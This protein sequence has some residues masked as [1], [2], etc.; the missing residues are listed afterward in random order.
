MRRALAGAAMSALLAACSGAS[1]NT[2]GNTT[3]YVSGD[4]SITVV[5]V[6]DRRPAP[7][8]AGIDLHG[9]P[10][11]ADELGA[12][13]PGAD[14][15]GGAVL[16][17]NVWGSWCAPCRREAPVLAKAALTYRE[18]GVRFL[19]LLS[20]DKPAAALAFNRAFNVPYP[21]LQDPGGRLQLR[22]ADSLPGQ[23]VPNTWVIDR[24]GRVAARIMAEVSEST[25][26]SV[27]DEVGLDTPAATRP[28]GVPK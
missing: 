18:R 10:L 9:K 19:G 20:R 8:L 26:R 16:V 11:S 27:L 14:V 24:D 1:P 4:G 22:F 17:V 12:D 28:P 25:L 21:S 6:E 15:R 7:V 2:G 5:P 3:G 13:V 23:A